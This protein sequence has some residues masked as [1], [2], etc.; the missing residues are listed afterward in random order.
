MAPV[1]PRFSHANLVAQ[2]G[3]IV[4]ASSSQS[5]LPPSFVR[6]PL[7]SQVWR[8]AIGQASAWLLADLVEAGEV[9][10]ACILD[11]N[12]SPAGTATLEAND[13]DEW[14]GPPFSCPLVGDDEKRLVFF[15][16]ASYR[17][18]RVVLSDPANADG[19]LEVG[20]LWLGT[21]FEPSRSHQHGYRETTR[22]LTVRAEAEEGAGFWDLRPR[23]RGWELSFGGLRPADKAAFDALHDATELFLALDPL[24]APTRT[25]YGHLTDPIDF[26]MRVGDGGERW[27]ATLSFEEALG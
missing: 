1:T 18:W 5:A 8:S 3:T 11:H 20:V 14:S 27:Q 25:L 24:N 6:T 7:R 9:G 19:F 22:P 23:A 17:Y 2:H 26:Q 15:E 16:P 21:Y 13:T 12:L 10:F 4:S